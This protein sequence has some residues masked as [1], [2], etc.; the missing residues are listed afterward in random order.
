MQRFEI[1][2]GALGTRGSAA[3]AA[4][5]VLILSDF[6]EQK[7]VDLA[8]FPVLLTPRLPVTRADACV[9][10][11]LAAYRSSRLRPY[12]GPHPDRYHVEVRTDDET[13]TRRLIDRLDSIGFAALS[14]RDAAETTGFA[15]RWSEGQV[16]P[17][18]RRSVDRLVAEELKA[19]GVPETAIPKST[20]EPG[21]PWQTIRI[22][23]PI[24]THE[25]EG[26]VSEFDAPSPSP[27]DC[28]SYDLRFL[29][30]DAAMRKALVEE[31]S[32]WGFERVDDARQS[33]VPEDVGRVEFGGAPP[34]V[35]ARI[36]EHLQTVT[37]ER[38]ESEKEWGDHDNDI[39]VYLPESMTARSEPRLAR[40]PGAAGIDLDS[41]LGQDT[42]G[43]ED[44]FIGV[45]AKA[46]TIADVDLPRQVGNR[47]SL[48]PDPA[49]FAHYCLDARTAETLRHVAMSAA[50]HEP[51]L[52]EGETSTSK[53][54]SIFYL[55]ALVGQPIVRL[56]LNGQTDTGELVG[57]FVPQHRI[58]KL[59]IDVEELRG[60]GHLLESETRY[61][62]DRVQREERPLSAFEVQQVIA[63]EKLHTLPWTWQDGLVPLAMKEGWWLLLDEVNLAEPQILE[64]LNSVLEPLPMLVLTEHDNSIIGSGGTPVHPDFRIFATMNPA[65]YAG[66]MALS[67]AY[68]DRWRG[69]RFVPKPGD[70][71]YSDML[72]FLV[73]GD[74][75]NVVVLGRQYRG[76]VSPA[77]FAVLADV[78]NIATFLNRLARFHSSLEE[79]SGGEGGARR[80]GSRRKEA[81]VFSRRTLLSILDYLASPLSS[82][83][84]FD[85]ELRLREALHR[86]YLNRITIGSDQEMVV[87]LLDASG[88]G[89]N[90]WE[91]STDIVPADRQTTVRLESFSR[92]I[93]VIRAVRDVLD[94][95]VKA[96]KD[97]VEADLPI[98]LAEDI[99]WLRADAMRDAIVAADP[100][101]RVSLT[102]VR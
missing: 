20:E 79:A 53:T 57:R 69:Y 33:R 13:R 76:T 7:E 58:T 40:P 38:F 50:L 88:I 80:L 92:K 42:A 14:V 59:P 26:L 15:V 83:A 37:G 4:R 73:F 8:R 62:L 24:A 54:S 94:V 81:Y 35:V 9:S 39:W 100:E 28:G 30:T 1:D 89:P 66:R 93:N 21:M 11:P 72:R 41:W 78:S 64:R 96:A 90:C 71:E 55:A 46:V 75:P 52:L 31:F 5:L 56:N 101:A 18:V 74:Q 16:D 77:P 10:V 12:T 6:L 95:S 49:S 91:I 27:D 70:P 22:D 65:E 36:I 86:Y 63:N 32:P 60:A 51:C 82:G 99:P 48:T 85:P 68:R 2:P 45:S 84:T 87:R 3:D 47:H 25:L 102:D 98:T 29:G 43:R 19:L 17:T 97:M 67:P 23:L 34:D 44:E 61:I